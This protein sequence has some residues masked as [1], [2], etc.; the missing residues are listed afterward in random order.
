MNSYANWR[1][2]YTNTPSPPQ[3]LHQSSF[4]LDGFYLLTILVCDLAII[5]YNFTS[6]EFTE[7]AM[8]R[9]QNY[10]NA[11]SHACFV[12]PS[13]MIWNIYRMDSKA[14]I[15]EGVMKNS[16][17]NRLRLSLDNMI[18]SITALFLLAPV[19][20]RFCGNQESIAIFCDFDDCR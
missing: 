3:F 1:Y 13:L 7:S 17:L 16:K 6:L 9:F 15:A 18:R 8:F 14:S 11:F 20:F 5:L 4:L 19:Y 2:N 12:Y 10:D